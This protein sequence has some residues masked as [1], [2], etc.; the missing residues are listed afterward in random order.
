MTHCGQGCRWAAAALALLGATGSCD[1]GIDPQLGIPTI[2]GTVTFKGQPPA[3]T[4]WV[5]VVA[6]RDFP[7]TDVVALAQ[8]QSAPLGLSGDRAE[9]RI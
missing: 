5:I 4:E 1:H 7:P 6:S 3:S 8:S 9:Y 2:Q